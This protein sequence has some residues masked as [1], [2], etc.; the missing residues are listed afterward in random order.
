MN[1]K[2]TGLSSE[3]ALNL[4]AQRNWV[5]NHYDENSQGEYDSVNGKLILLDT[6]LKSG[7]IEKQ[8]TVK[9]QSLGVTLGD[10]FVQESGFEWIEVEDEY[11]LDP[12]IM[13]PGTKII[14]YPLTMISKRVEN[15]EAIDVYNLYNGI[16]KIVTD[17]QAN[18]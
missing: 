17:I 1:Q 7:W 14:L 3:T 15:D 8:E 11:G 2:I 5:R 16:Q 18:S 9:L 6:I 12:A 4:A 13:L 10:V